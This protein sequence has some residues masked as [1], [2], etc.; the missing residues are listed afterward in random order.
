MAFDP[1]TL[2][3]LIF[4]VIILILGIWVYQAKKIALAIFVAIGFGLFAISHLATL[5]GA[6]SG[7]ISI[8][9]IRTLAYLVII[10]AL[11]R[12]AMKK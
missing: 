12:E 11:A 6:S 8:I 10:Y 2:L 9:V 3:N 7:E 5:L 1:T 4:A